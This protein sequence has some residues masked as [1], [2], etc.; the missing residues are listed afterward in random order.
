M[1]VFA[2]F[3]G[4]SRVGTTS[5]AVHL[6]RA[7]QCVRFASTIAWTT[8][9]PE[10]AVFVIHTSHP[11]VHTYRLQACEEF[12][13]YCT[14]LVARPVLDVVHDVL[15]AGV[16]LLAPRHRGMCERDVTV[17]AIVCGARTGSKLGGRAVGKGRGRSRGAGGAVRR[18][19][20]HVPCG[21]ASIA[22]TD[23]HTHTRVLYMHTE[24]RFGGRPGECRVTDMLTL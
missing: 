7:Q 4:T 2:V 22:D 11:S 19:A 12:I 1:I 15:S 5:A 10:P 24:Y 16:V 13:L 23:A 6:R 8:D 9:A 18:T 20:R 3:D 21:C 14:N 17:L